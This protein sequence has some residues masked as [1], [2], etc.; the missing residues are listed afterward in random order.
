MR[1]NQLSWKT[2]IKTLIES[3]NEYGAVVWRESEH[4]GMKACENPVDDFPIEKTINAELFIDR[5]ARETRIRFCDQW[6]WATCAVALVDW[7]F[8]HV[9][10]AVVLCWYQKALV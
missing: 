10:C 4:V 2:G 3:T 6:G 1:F 8:K 9:P 7:M 5:A